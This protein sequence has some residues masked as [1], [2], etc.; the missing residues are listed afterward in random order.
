MELA[1]ERYISSPLLPNV[2]PDDEMDV[3]VYWFVAA[4]ATSDN[5]SAEAQN[6]SIVGVE[7]AT[8][9]DEEAVRQGYAFDTDYRELAVKAITQG[10]NGREGMPFVS[11]VLG[12]AIKRVSFAGYPIFAGIEQRCRLGDDGNVVRSWPQLIYPEYLAQAGNRALLKCID[13]F[14][15]EGHAPPAWMVGNMYQKHHTAKL[16][17][18]FA[19]N[20]VRMDDEL[21]DDDTMYH[22]MY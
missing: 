21:D 8:L 10:M 16:L 1:G 15:K 12:E 19:L 17:A 6:T 2:R 7:I 11:S 4:P 14:R 18:L 9:P 22:R 5:M 20:T 13:S 3:P